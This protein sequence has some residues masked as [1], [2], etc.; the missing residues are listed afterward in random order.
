[1]TEIDLFINNISTSMNEELGTSE[2]LYRG[3]SFESRVRR[4]NLNLY[5]EKMKT[6]S[7]KVLFLGE[8][9]GYKGC[10]L[11]GIPFTSEKMV[12][13]NSF[14]SSQ[15]YKFINSADKL[16]S[17]ISATIV[18]NELESFERKPLIWNIFPFHPYQENDP[19]SNRTPN[20]AELNLGREVL[21]QLLTIFSIEKI[22]AVGRKPESRLTELGIDFAY[23]RHPANGGK[24]DFFVP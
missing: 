10:K 6:T 11:T 19:N 24:N 21:E 12:A 9:P 18:W 8:A 16:E 3:N 23:V 7:P 15:D 5:L 1:M 22:V 17:E 20:N 4:W 2:N 13:A 14:F